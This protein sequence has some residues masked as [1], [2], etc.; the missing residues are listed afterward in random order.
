[1]L[2]TSQVN[3]EQLVYSEDSAT[4]PELVHLNSLSP[5]NYVNASFR[6][7]RHCPAHLVHLVFVTQAVS[8]VAW[9]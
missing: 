6:L 2:S 5:S 9:Q 7:V 3:I 4:M 1:M 8:I